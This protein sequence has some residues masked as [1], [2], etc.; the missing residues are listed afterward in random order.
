M[1]T[2][3]WILLDNTRIDTSPSNL[4]ILGDYLCKR[5]F[6]P[7]ISLVYDPHMAESIHLLNLSKLNR[8]QIDEIRQAAEKYL[9]ITV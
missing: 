7:I 5:G 3:L 1:R 4:K 8:T 9:K 2:P 6:D